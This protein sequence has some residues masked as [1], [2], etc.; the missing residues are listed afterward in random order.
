AAT[1]IALSGGFA[2]GVVLVSAQDGFSKNL[3]HY[4]VGDILAVSTGDLTATVV[5]AAA[6][7]LVVAV[8]GKELLFTA[9]DPVGASAVGLPTLLLD[10]VLLAV[11]QVTVVVTVPALGAIL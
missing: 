2:L 5:V 6:V 8:L 1:G 11:I 9:F 7:V 4:M 10:F 3:T